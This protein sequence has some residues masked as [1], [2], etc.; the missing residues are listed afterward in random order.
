MPSSR[1]ERPR[2]KK[3]RTDSEACDI[4]QLGLDFIL[5]DEYSTD[6]RKEI[7]PMN[8]EQIEVLEEKVNDILEKYSDLK[9]ENARLNEEV[10]RLFSEREGLKSRVDAILDKLEGI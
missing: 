7:E 9:A 1:T 2:E 10:H 8:Q 6:P 4:S 5:P 3:R